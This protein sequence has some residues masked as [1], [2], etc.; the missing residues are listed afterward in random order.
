M[1]THDSRTEIH[2]RVAGPLVDRL[3]EVFMARRNSGE[4]IDVETYVAE[5]P[6]WEAPLRERLTLLESKRSS[7][8]NADTLSAGSSAT[9]PL[10]PHQSMVERLGGYRLLKQ[11]GQG[12]MG[13]VFLAVQESLDRTVAVKL[14]RGGNAP[15]EAIQRFEQEAKAA[16]SLKHPNIVAVHEFGQHDGAPYLS[17][18]F[19]AGASLSDLTSERPLPPREAAAYMVAIA[20]AIQC[21]HDARI[22]HRDLK[23][24]NILIDEQKQPK[25]TD[26]GLAK[27]LEQPADLTQSGGIV[28]TPA[29]M[30][31]EQ[32]TLDKDVRTTERSDI[33]SLGATLYSIVT[34][35]APHVAATPIDTIRL[36][37]AQEPV[38]PRNLNTGIDRDLE[39]ICLKCL[40]KDPSARYQTAGALRDDLQRFLN[41]EPILARPESSLSKLRRWTRKNPAIATLSATIAGVVLLSAVVLAMFNYRLQQSLTQTEIHKAEA[42][43]RFSDLFEVID[44]QYTLISEDE[45][46]REPGMT[47]LRKELLRRAR[48][49]YAAFVQS[50]ANDEKHVQRTALAHFRLGEIARTLNEK[51]RAATEYDAALAFQQ[52]LH[53]EQP[54]D[55]DLTQELSDTFNAQG[56]LH[57]ANAD[58]PAAVEAFKQ[59]RKLRE[60]WHQKQP[61]AAAKRKLANTLM[62]LGIVYRKQK[63]AAEA[64]ALL[65][66]AQRLRSDAVKLPDASPET[67]VGLQL[68]RD[69]AK[70][71]YGIY[72]YYVDLETAPESVA[73]RLAQLQTAGKYQF[74][75]CQRSPPNLSED[76]YFFVVLL[77]QLAVEQAA[78]GNHAA[79]AVF[80][81]C[82]AAIEQ[83]ARTNPSVPAYQAEAGAVCLEQA[84]YHLSLGQTADVANMLQRARAWLQPL[85]ATGDKRW[86]AEF[87]KVQSMQQRLDALPAK[88]GQT[89]D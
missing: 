71:S 76:R 87:E 34:G 9:T 10:A 82:R 5:H 6:G 62:N 19:V 42:E 83:I 11:I 2:N 29:F 22:L 3:V 89:V 41:D 47:A 63:K 17:M 35:R 81:Q 4:E 12:G 45:L 32:A 15:A 51:E 21:A 56:A 20:D 73:A 18:E 59:S 60:M 66:A 85:A 13:V 23:P 74:E 58:L 50:R 65:E 8:A 16:A 68:Q 80:M 53:K 7:L 61:G 75:V 78:Q 55:L 1:T 40:A 70:G 49:Y 52:Q 27:F 33:Y 88:G 39:T 37:I 36:V 24:S 14:I 54:D 67:M 31:P 30:A 46:L 44:Q 28:G 48:D 57:V 79:A 72:Q 25:V 38:A 77:R 84:N 26:F 69:L 64:K 43:Q 86:V